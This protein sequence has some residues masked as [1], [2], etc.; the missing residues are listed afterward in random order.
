MTGLTDK[1]AAIFESTLQL[2]REHGFHGTP[3]SLIAK[4]AG[5]A[6][7]TIYHHFDSKDTLICELYE[8]VVRQMLDALLQHDEEKMPYEERFFN[9]FIS[10]CLFYIEH[11]CA[12]FFMEQFVN[13]PYNNGSGRADTERSP[14]TFRHLIQYGVNQGLLRDM[15]YRIIGS[16]VH[17]AVVS[18]AKVHLC[19]KISLGQPELRQITRMIWDG[20]RNPEAS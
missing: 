15:D 6:A 19:R 5:V 3:M 20:I 10:H 1:K 16:L 12:L 14:G 8:H 7:G 18:T 4:K 13:S 11:P 17:G 2:I 9:F